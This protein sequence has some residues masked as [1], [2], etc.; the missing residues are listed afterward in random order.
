M[1][2]ILKATIAIIVIAG[3]TAIASCTK[4]CDLGYEGDHCTTRATD[5]YVG[6]FSGR[7]NCGGP[8]DT[9][10]V[11]ITAITG[12]VTKVKINNIYNA[13]L[14]TTTGT[15]LDNGSISIASQPLGTATISGNV[16]VISG[17]I[18]IAYLINGGGVSN[19]NCTWV[20]N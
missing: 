9:F 19:V 16:T 4:T 17:K 2:K 8:T 15:L 7:E 14:N 3:I 12:D 6:T 13:G 20:Q 18:N 5:K 1:N 10:S 11:A